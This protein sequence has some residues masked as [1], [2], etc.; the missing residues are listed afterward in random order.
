[1]SGSKGEAEKKKILAEMKKK[2]VHISLLTS[3]DTHTDPERTLALT[4][5]PRM[6][7]WRYDL[8]AP[9]ISARSVQ[10]RSDYRN[11]ISLGYIFKNYDCR[12]PPPN[13]AKHGIH[14]GRAFRHA[15][16]VTLHR[17]VMPTAGKTDTVGG[18]DG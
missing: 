6:T 10:A 3:L 16:G 2:G 9:L 17:G 15:L 11:R 12:R 8:H 5:L 14:F 4:W 7:V 18:D 13:D 1:M